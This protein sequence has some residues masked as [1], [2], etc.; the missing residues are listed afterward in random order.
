[1]KF[2][3]VN[4]DRTPMFVP[5]K[6]IVNADLI[7]DS[8][9]WHSNGRIFRIEY[10]DLELSG[11]TTEMLLTSDAVNSVIEWSEM[12]KRLHHLYK[13]SKMTIPHVEK[14]CSIGGLIDSSERKSMVS[15][16]EAVRKTVSPSK[17]LQ[18]G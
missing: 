12:V 8:K 1:M 18:T 17:Y 7:E 3:A 5:L 6:S 4:M 9:S 13:M 11:Q 14:N 2:E 16:I 15:P 10:E